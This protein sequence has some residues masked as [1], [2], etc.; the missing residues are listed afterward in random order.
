MA[1]LHMNR[2]FIG[3][4]RVR[5]LTTTRLRALMAEC[6]ATVLI[7]QRKTTAKIVY[8]DFFVSFGFIWTRRL[9]SFLRIC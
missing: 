4:G 5:L 8:D 2:L 1:P 9:D 6:K 3:G 7:G